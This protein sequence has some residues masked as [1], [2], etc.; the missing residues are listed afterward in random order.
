M[1][2]S[3]LK[4]VEMPQTQPIENGLTER[5]SVI[6]KEQLQLLKK[7]TDMRKEMPSVTKSGDNGKYK[8][9]TS[10]DVL[11]V[12]RDQMD[13]HN[14]FLI[15]NIKEKNLQTF[16]LDSMQNGVPHRKVTYFTEMW[17]EYTWV[18]VD[19]GG[20]LTTT[21]YSQ[22][23]DVNGE[24]SVGKAMTYAEKYLMLK[25]FQI[26][27]DED[28]D[29]IN[30][31]E[32]LKGK[33]IVTT[34]QLESVD[35]K[36]KTLARLQGK[37]HEDL[38]Q[39]ISSV[40]NGTPLQSISF[41]QY[42]LLTMRL[43]KSIADEQAKL[44]QNAN[45]IESASETTLT[46]QNKVNAPSQQEILELVAD[47]EMLEQVTVNGCTKINAHR[48]SLELDT[49]KGKLLVRDLDAV[50]KLEAINT[51]IVI[52]GVIQNQSG[53]KFL[54]NIQLDNMHGA[55]S[56][57]SNVVQTSNETEVSTKETPNGT[58][59]EFPY[60]SIRLRRKPNNAEYATVTIGNGEVVHC[61]IEEDIKIL[62]DLSALE[63]FSCEV[64][65][66]DNFRFIRSVKPLE[67]VNA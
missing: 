22:G 18:D 9:A 5:F 16:A 8:F 56:S 25:T 63:V 39:F 61:E 50:K 57:E 67:A 32:G 6:P 3:A 51:P 33:R 7:M 37:K 12:V 2:E 47:N 44:N 38:M 10:A 19:S 36:I 14:I 21:I 23:I 13:K 31:I 62:R 15:P 52:E 24:K 66:V 1:T 42:E 43:D 11:A 46:N 59:C 45:R 27:T 34:E 20:A 49:D 48:P 53:F 65:P 58:Y 54:V 29:F 40:I 35:M 26:P 41:E 64:Y 17:I 55:I 60:H 4:V 28:P 30:G